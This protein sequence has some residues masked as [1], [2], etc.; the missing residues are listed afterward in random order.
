M[1]R[2]TTTTCLILATLVLGACEAPAALRV[3]KLEATHGLP[4]PA[5]PACPAY[6]S[7]PAEPTVVPGGLY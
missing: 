2:S 6:P 3:E 1:N 4:C 5:C 7:A